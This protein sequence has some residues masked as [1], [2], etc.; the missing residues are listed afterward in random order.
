MKKFK[1]VNILLILMM[2]F[3]IPV[4]HAHEVEVD[5]DNITIQSVEGTIYSGSEI[6]VNKEKLGISDYEVY[7]QY[8]V[9]ENQ[10][11]K[12]YME[13]LEEQNEYI[14]NFLKDNNLEDI[15]DASNELKEDYIAAMEGFIEEAETILP[16]YVEDNW[17]KST[18][19]T[20]KLDLTEV[21]ENSLG[22]QPYSLWIK[23][24]PTDEGKEPVYNDIV[25]EAERQVVDSE[26]KEEN[27]STGDGV[28]WIALSAVVL[29]GI[30]VVSYKKSNA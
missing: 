30:M 22:F 5:K 27:A 1:F 28:M 26:L 8:V 15:N 18:D 29:A 14:K 23:V 24:V 20:T 13:K 11:Y 6:V 17:V 16:A 21:P 12:L 25:V 9:I 7:Y 3:T 2:I 19:G 4:A 10:V